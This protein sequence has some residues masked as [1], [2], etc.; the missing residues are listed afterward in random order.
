M[1]SCQKWQAR[2]GL[3]LDRPVDLGGAPDEDVVMEALLNH[4]MNCPLAP[5][6]QETERPQSPPELGDLGGSRTDILHRCIRRFSNAVM[7]TARQQ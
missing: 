2:S 7:D 6:A 1:N 3:V 4:G 5:S